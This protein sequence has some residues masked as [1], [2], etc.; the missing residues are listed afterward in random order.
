MK[1][2]T[3]AANITYSGRTFNTKLIVEY[4]HTGKQFFKNTRKGKHYLSGEESAKKEKGKIFVSDGYYFI[5]RLAIPTINANGENDIWYINN[6]GDAYSVNK[7]SKFGKKI[8][9]QLSEEKITIYK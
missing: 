6:F 8:H 5:D 3:F 1:K 4:K 7:V 2:Y 9:Q